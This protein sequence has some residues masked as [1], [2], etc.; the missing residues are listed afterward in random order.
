MTYNTLIHY[1]RTRSDLLIPFRR[2]RKID[3]RLLLNAT[4][5]TSTVSLKVRFSSYSRFRESTFSRVLEGSSL[6]S[7]LTDSSP[8][9]LFSGL[10]TSPVLDVT[11]PGTPDTTMMV[12]LSKP[13]YTRLFFTRLN[14]IT[15]FKPLVQSTEVQKTI[16]SLCPLDKPL[17][18]FICTT[19]PSTYM[20][21]SLWTQ[22]N[23][24]LKLYH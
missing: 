11:R 14:V 9:F 1:H 22:F 24:H 7:G 23:R 15:D 4:W 17:G 10:S 19:Q 2:T 13:S 8:S 21:K 3:S 12:T 18:K 6:F 5:S 20:Y 16:R